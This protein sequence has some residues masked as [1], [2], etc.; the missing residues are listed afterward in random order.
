MKIIFVVVCFL[1]IQVLKATDLNEIES[2]VD[3]ESDVIISKIIEGLNL[4]RS[5]KCKSDLNFTVNALHE[6][7]PWAV[8]SKND[9]D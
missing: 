8:G 1:L 4:V 5:S 2:S 3:A 6:R 7:Q 9:F